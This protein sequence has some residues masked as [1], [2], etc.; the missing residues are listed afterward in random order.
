MLLCFEFGECTQWQSRWS[1]VCVL[2]TASCTHSK[3]HCTLLPPH[4]FPPAP[5]VLCCAV[6]CC[7]VLCCAVLCVVVQ[8][9]EEQHTFLDRQVALLRCSL[10]PL[11]PDD[12]VGGG[13]EVCR[14]VD[15]L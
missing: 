15:C 13:E 8:V 10:E 11:T 12:K 14:Q 3:P 9:I 4:I 6:L 2:W 1:A 7:A 5:A